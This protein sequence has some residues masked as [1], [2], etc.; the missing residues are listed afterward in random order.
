MFKYKFDQELEKS[1]KDEFKYAKAGK[2]RNSHFE[3][4]IWFLRDNGEEVNFQIHGFF[5]VSQKQIYIYEG[6]LDDVFGGWARG[7][8]VPLNIEADL[9]KTAYIVALNFAYLRDLM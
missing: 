9:S 6:R 4:K 5:D 2:Y 3:G 1:F 8:E 7:F